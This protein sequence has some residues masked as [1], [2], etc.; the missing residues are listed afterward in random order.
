MALGVT[1]P[2]VGFINLQKAGAGAGIYL[3]ISVARPANPQNN[4]IP[5]L[6]NKSVYPSV[7]IKGKR[8]PSVT[9][10]TIA[11]ASWFTAANLNDLIVSLDSNYDTAYYNV[12]L[13]DGNST[14]VYD[15]SRCTRLSLYQQ[16]TSGIGVEM[17]FLTV[18]GE[19][20]GV[21]STMSPPA[22]PDAGIAF[23]PADTTFTGAN[24]VYN[25]RADLIRGV[26]WLQVLDGTVYADSTVDGMFSGKFQLT[27]TPK[28]TQVPTTSCLVGI[29]S[30]PT[31]NLAMTLLYEGLDWSQ[32]PV[33]GS[34]TRY[35]TLIDAVLGGNP[36][37]F[38]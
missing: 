29:G 32:E 20:E 33:I 6:V 7:Y 11:K 18:H 35:Y 27:Q 5:A 8:T 14:R 25:W 37:V 38:S 15:Q 19:S 26:G 10:Q 12:I 9:I 22:N 28:A 17:E 31:V 30:I 16:A 4:I 1:K 23:G 2:F 13:Y 36:S 24:G 3:P 21:G 34:A